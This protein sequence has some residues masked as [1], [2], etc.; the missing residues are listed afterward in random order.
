[1]TA[2][3]KE[4]H[5]EA[6]YATKKLTE[7]SWYQPKPELSLNLIAKLGLPKSASLIDIGGG[8]SFLTDYLLESGYADLS[9]LDISETALQR[10]KMRL[11]KK[12]NQVNWI[13]ADA[14]QFCPTKQFDVWHDRAAF[15]FLTTEAD[16]ASYVKNATQAIKKGGYLIIGTF[17]ENG[18]KKCSGIEIKQYSTET[19]ALLFNPY[20]DLVE[21]FTTDHI[22]PS[23]AIQNF[24]FCVMKK[25]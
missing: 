16:V 20:F 1:M 22:T 3:N 14:A 2:F 11:D 13:V 7:V 15:H 18:P 4:K 9:V 5:W 21:G 24:A 12:A 17:S 19:L 25:R 10:A 6:I 8:D 23:G